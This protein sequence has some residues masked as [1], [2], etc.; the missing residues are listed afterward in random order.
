M[1]II[2]FTHD[3]SKTKAI[4]FVEHVLV[5]KIGTQHLIV[6]H[7][8]HFGYGGDGTYDTIDDC[9]GSMGFVVEQVRGLSDGGIAIS[10]SRIREA[11]LKGSLDDANNWLGYNYSLKG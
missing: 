2:N 3:F 8:H 10:S 4:D 11:L 1:V 9:A 7:D 5:G 6:G